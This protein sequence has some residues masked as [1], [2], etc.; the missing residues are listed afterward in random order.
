MDKILISNDFNRL[1]QGGRQ[2]MET[3]AKGLMP[4]ASDDFHAVERGGK[5]RAS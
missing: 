1:E 2:K 3:M 4:S 5:T